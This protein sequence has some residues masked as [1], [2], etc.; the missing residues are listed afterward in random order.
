VAR[1]RVHRLDNAHWREAFDRASVPEWFRKRR[2]E[3][4]WNGPTDLHDSLPPGSVP[5]WFSNREWETGWNGSTARGRATRRASVPKCFGKHP[6]PSLPQPDSRNL[7]ASGPRPGPE[8]AG[9]ASASSRV[10]SGQPRRVRHRLVRTSDELVRSPDGCNPPTSGPRAGPE[11]AGPASR[12]PPPRPLEATSHTRSVPRRPRVLRRPP[13]PRMGIVG[14]R[15]RSP[16]PGG[17]SLPP[18]RQITRQTPRS[19]PCRRAPIDI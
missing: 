13:A 9:P 14:L 5:E 15:S 18:E 1:G 6:R 19:P 8:P 11:P 10:P 17:H 7:P 2:R 3:T 12:P 4:E 16:G